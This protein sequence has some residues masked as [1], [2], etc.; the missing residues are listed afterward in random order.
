MAELAHVCAHGLPVPLEL[1]SYLFQAL[2]L[3][4]LRLQPGP[5]LLQLCQTPHQAIVSASV[6]QRFGTRKRSFSACAIL[7][8]HGVPA[9]TG[10][11]LCLL[12]PCNLK[13][14]A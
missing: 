11:H 7:C 9:W 12:S 3:C 6:S 14:A 5:Q 8:H 13:R 1:L 4:T 2:P 10:S